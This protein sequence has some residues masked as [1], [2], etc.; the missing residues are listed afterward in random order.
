LKHYDPTKM[1]KA[2][3][4]K[5]AAQAAERLDRAGQTL[6]GRFAALKRD[7]ADLAAA[8]G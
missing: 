4:L 1:P 6:S 2:R 3:D 5:S 7:A 8:M